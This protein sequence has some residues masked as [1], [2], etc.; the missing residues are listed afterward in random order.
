MKNGIGSTIVKLPP[1]IFYATAIGLGLVTHHFFPFELLPEIWK[2]RI[3]TVLF[4]I[5]G[6]IIPFILIRYNKL[7]TP[8]FNVY[9]PAR[10][11]VTDGP[12]RFSRNPGY[13]VLTLLYLGIAVNLNNIWILGLSIPLILVVDLLIIRREEKELEEIFGESFL[14]YKSAVRRWI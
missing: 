9:K 13:V 5:S 8:F 7:K 3:G 11:L 6:A 4:S 10:A 14:Q 2:G 1:P 12:N